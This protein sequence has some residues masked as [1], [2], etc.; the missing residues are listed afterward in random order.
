MVE[1]AKAQDV[2]AGDGTTSAVVV[3]GAL[4]RAVQTLLEKGIHCSAIVDT[5]L[6]AKVI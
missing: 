3:A 1:M 2:E 5:F 4:L 6:L